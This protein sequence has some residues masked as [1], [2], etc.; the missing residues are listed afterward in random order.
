ME[1]LRR[2]ADKQARIGVIGLGYV[3]LPLAVEFAQAGFHVVG[4]DVDA[5]KVDG[6]ERRPQLHPRRRRP[7][8]AGRGGRRPAR[9]ARHRPTRARSPTS[10]SSTSACRRRCARPRTRTCPTSSQAVEA[11]AAVLRRG[12]ARHPR[13]D[14][15]SRARPTRWCSRCSRPSG[16]RPARDFYLAFS[17]ERVDPGQPDVPRPRT[18]RRSS[19]ASTTRST[20]LA[21]ALYAQ[22][23][24]T[25]VPV[26]S[27]ARRRDGQAAR[28]H[29]PR[30]E[31]RPGQRAGADVR[32]A[33]ASTSGK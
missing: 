8:D 33:W 31:H 2:I 24:D 19:A 7:T 13:V 23:I 26:S 21:A 15:L 5:A 10:T 25:V 14:D 4:Y 20:E 17:P 9:F 18:S 32:P 12:P 28:E 30:R 1:L 22:V 27:T 11:I 3:G 16:L 29:L 6:A